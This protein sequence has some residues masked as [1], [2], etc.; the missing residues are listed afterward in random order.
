MLT[1]YLSIYHFLYICLMKTA[2]RSFPSPVARPPPPLPS[3][4]HWTLN[5]FLHARLLIPKINSCAHLCPYNTTLTP[6]AGGILSEK[7]SGK[8]T[9]LCSFTVRHQFDLSTPYP[10]SLSCV[11]FFSPHR[12]DRLSM[13]PLSPK[14]SII[15]QFQNWENGHQNEGLSLS[16]QV[17]CFVHLQRKTHF[18]R[19]RISSLL[20]GGQRNCN[21]GPLA[22]A[23]DQ[24]CRVAL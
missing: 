4:H 11:D 18:R 16:W 17:T 14:C 10:L 24:S 8:K 6:T 2:S 3:C 23:Q 21:W 19:S 15:S 7:N 9:S 20:S 13:E 5:L 22:V 12:H 1:I